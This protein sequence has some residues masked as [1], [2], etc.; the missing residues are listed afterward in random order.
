MKRTYSRSKEA[1][2]YHAL[3]DHTWRAAS[4]GYLDQHPLCRFHE[5]RGETAQADVTDHIIPHKGSLKLFWDRT[6]WQ[7]LCFNCHNS[8]KAQIER[9]G[10]HNHHGLDG[11]PTDPNHPFNRV[12]S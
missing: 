3:Y 9:H 10:Y 12:R 4:K 8:L 5:D 1:Q 11:L 6:N 2:A 7:P